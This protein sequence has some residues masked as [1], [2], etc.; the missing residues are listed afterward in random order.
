MGEI[1]FLPLL[2]RETSERNGRISLCIASDS[3]AR[4]SIQHRWDLPQVYLVFYIISH[5]HR[6]YPKM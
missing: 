6:D 4:V 5:I 2:K 3:V 1:S